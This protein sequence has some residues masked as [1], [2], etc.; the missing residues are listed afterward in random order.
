MSL[1]ELIFACRQILLNSAYKE[2]MDKFL[3]KRGVGADVRVAIWN[4]LDQDGN[5]I[6][7]NGKP[8]VFTVGLKGK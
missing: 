4:T 5:L 6:D 8:V 2:D 1:I 3:I 7:A